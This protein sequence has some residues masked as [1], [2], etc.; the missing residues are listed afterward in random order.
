MLK[1]IETFSR[2]T[3]VETSLISAPIMEEQISMKRQI[4]G[5]PIIKPFTHH[6]ILI[7]APL[8]LSLSQDIYQLRDPV[9]ETSQLFKTRKK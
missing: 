9:K 4:S 8:S 3:K 7:P 1:E 2:E 6:Q 5:P